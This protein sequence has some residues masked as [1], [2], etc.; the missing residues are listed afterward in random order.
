MRAR[1]V[2]PLGQCQADIVSFHEQAG[3]EQ[4]R[5]EQAFRDREQA[6]QVNVRHFVCCLDNVDLTI[7]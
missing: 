1:Y 5:R 4:A 7:F 3:Y 2:N 6:L